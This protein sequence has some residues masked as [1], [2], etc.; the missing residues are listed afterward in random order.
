MP[1]PASEAARYHFTPPVPFSP[2]SRNHTKLVF[3]SFYFPLLVFDRDLVKLFEVECPWYLQLD[4][5]QLV[6]S[7]RHPPTNMATSHL[8]V[9][10]PF[11]LTL[12]ELSASRKLTFC[13]LPTSFS[14]YDH[15]PISA[16][17]SHLFRRFPKATPNAT[18]SSQPSPLLARMVGIV[19]LL[20]DS[21]L[22]RITMRTYHRMSLRPHQTPEHRFRHL[23]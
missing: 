14:S 23:S 10:P 7:L 18:D 15:R 19:G 2:S 12:L 5:L 21:M 11:P 3:Y 8:P 16:S 20:L 17:L 4:Q 22:P 1:R 6:L 9:E 13:P